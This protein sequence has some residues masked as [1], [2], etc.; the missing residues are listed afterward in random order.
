MEYLYWIIIL[1]V[2]VVMMIIP[3]RRQKKRMQQ[4]MESLRLGVKVRT[5]GGFIG[6]IIAVY[7]DTVILELNP[8]KVR[9]EL[10]KGAVAPL[11]QE[12]NQ[13]AQATEE[14][15]KTEQEQNPP[16]SESEEQKSVGQEQPSSQSEEK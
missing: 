8:D 11:E 12:L 14:I 15:T 1:A 5:A 3:Q 9:V 13:T 4:M 10:L 7:D 16:L 2:F 6:T